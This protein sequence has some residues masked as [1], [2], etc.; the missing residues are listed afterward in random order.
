[1]IVANQVG[2]GIAFGQDD[3]KAYFIYEDK[4]TDLPKMSKLELAY[5][6]LDEACANIS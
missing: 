4:V 6:I 1:M 3:D 2:Y 5:K